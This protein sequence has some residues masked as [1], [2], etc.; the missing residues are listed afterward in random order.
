MHLLDCIL[1]L[2]WQSSSPSYYSTADEAWYWPKRILHSGWLYI[3]SRAV[4]RWMFLHCWFRLRGY[5]QNYFGTF[6]KQHCN[7]LLSSQRTGSPSLWL[8]TSLLCSGVSN[9]DCL[10]QTQYISSSLS[11]Y[12]D[13]A[14]GLDKLSHWETI[15][16]CVEHFH[17]LVSNV[18]FSYLGIFLSGYKWSFTFVVSVL[19]AGF[20][21]ASIIGTLSARVGTLNCSHYKSLV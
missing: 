12:T 11:H 13:N 3:T 20:P 10:W 18:V 6:T 5:L 17:N 7:Q 1:C 8:K 19:L 16:L 14:F 9:V 4:V 2:R 15:S 21:K